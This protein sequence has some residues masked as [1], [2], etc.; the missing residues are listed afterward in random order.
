MIP[1]YQPEEFVGLNCLELTHPEDRDDSTVSSGVALTPVIFVIASCNRAAG[2]ATP[3]QD[4]IPPHI[5]RETSE[6]QC[7]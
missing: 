3:P 5:G 1:G 7:C 6:K 4:F 2:L